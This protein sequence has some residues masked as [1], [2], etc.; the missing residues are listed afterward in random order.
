MDGGR[1]LHRFQGDSGRPARAKHCTM[2]RKDA[3]KA[4][5]YGYCAWH[6]KRWQCPP[7]ASSAS[8]NFSFHPNLSI[9]TRRSKPANAGLGAFL[10]LLVAFL[11]PL[12]LSKEETIG[13]TIASNHIAP[14]KTAQLST[15]HAKI[16]D[17]K[18]VGSARPKPPA[19]P[20]APVFIRTAP[21]NPTAPNLPTLGWGL[22]SFF[23]S[24][25]FLFCPSQKRKKRTFRYRCLA[26]KIAW[27]R[28]S[29]R[30]KRLALRS[31]F[32]IVA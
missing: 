12:P 7:K 14:I 29:S 30:R 13:K 22:F 24:L 21:S 5:S 27:S 15:R 32:A 23:W 26:A 17:T 3:G 11:S 16:P 31:T 10:F 19:R 20:K 25:F 1:L 28:Q 18:S 8:P 4:P 9:R 6:K 2:G